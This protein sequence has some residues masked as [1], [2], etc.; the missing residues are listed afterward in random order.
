MVTI[1]N[2][3]LI[4][5]KRGV[6]KTKGGPNY[7]KY[8][9]NIFRHFTRKER[10]LQIINHQ[11]GSI[12]FYLIDEKKENIENLIMEYNNLSKEMMP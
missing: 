11:G 1:N 9:T 10:N 5:S 7:K 6:A 12:N 4:G 8:L 3:E 2:D